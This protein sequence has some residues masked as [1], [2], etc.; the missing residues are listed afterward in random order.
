MATDKQKENIETFMARG[1]KRSTRDRIYGM[2]EEDFTDHGGIDYLND[3]ELREISEKIK[4][5]GYDKLS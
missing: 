1:R 5:G 3:R 2:S 4:R